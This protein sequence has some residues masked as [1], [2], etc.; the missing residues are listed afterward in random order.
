MNSLPGT[1]AVRFA[2]TSG[3]GSAQAVK[4]PAASTQL[5]PHQAGPKVVQ[6]TAG[7]WLWGN[8]PAL[9][10]CADIQ[11]QRHFCALPHS[12]GWRWRWQPY[13]ATSGRSG[14]LRRPCT[15]R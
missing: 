11:D 14:W 1:E 8:K 5:L 3:Q 12:S 13:G 6:V 9:R 15:L 7:G 2:T 10:G 4:Q